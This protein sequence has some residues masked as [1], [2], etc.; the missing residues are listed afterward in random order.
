MNLETYIPGSKEKIIAQIL[1]L[2]Y[3]MEDIIAEGKEAHP[4]AL[5]ELRKNS[6][7]MV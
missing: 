6:R 2:E 1:A 3:A 5:H 4:A 7:Q